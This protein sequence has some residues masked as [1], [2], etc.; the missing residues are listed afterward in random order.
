[1]N[2]AIFST[3]PAAGKVTSNAPKTV[4]CNSNHSILPS[5]FMPIS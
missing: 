3:H 1:L 2:I 4:N 5:V